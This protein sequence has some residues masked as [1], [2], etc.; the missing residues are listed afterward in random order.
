MFFY[1]FDIDFFAYATLV[2]NLNEKNF[3]DEKES[4]DP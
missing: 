4:L 3:E 2:K 1:C